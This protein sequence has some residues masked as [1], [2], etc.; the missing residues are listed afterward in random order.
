[1]GSAIK[2]GAGDSGQII[3]PGF[4]GACRGDALTLI[5]ASEDTVWSKYWAS[6][7]GPATARFPGPARLLRGDKG[8]WLGEN[9][10]L[11]SNGGRNR[12]DHKIYA[13][14]AGQQHGGNKRAIDQHY[15]KRKTVHAGKLGNPRKGNVIHLRVPRRFQ[16]KPVIRSRKSSMATQKTGASSKG[17]RFPS[18]DRRAI[19]ITSSPKTA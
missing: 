8:L 11:Q 5:C 18:V 13:S 19:S 7:P 12:R 6:M 9:S 16:G 1:L 10:Y 4:P 15:G 3:N 14:S 2:K 17:L